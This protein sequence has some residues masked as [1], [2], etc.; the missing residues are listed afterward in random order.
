ME[1]AGKESGI[2][3]M[4]K[5]EMIKKY[6]IYAFAAFLVALIIVLFKYLRI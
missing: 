2:L 4:S 5:R 3:F 6:L 1:E